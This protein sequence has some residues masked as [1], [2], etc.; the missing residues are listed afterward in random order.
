MRDELAAFEAADVVVDLGYEQ[1]HLRKQELRARSNYFAAFPE[2]E[3]PERFIY[4]PCTAEN[5]YLQFEFVITPALVSSLL[6]PRLVH[7]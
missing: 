1:V 3:F 6:V 7:H 5:F 4:R 2:E